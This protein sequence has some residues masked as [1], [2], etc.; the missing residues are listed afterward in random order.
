[1]EKNINNWE[2]CVFLSHI[3]N[4]PNSLHSDT[5]KCYEDLKSQ[6]CHIEKV[7]LSKLHKKTLNNWLRLKASINVIKWLMFKSY[8]LKDMI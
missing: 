5:I 7:Y 4:T 3:G 2:D 8:A 1:M 6:S